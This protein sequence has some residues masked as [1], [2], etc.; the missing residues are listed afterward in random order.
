MILFL[1]KYPQAPQEYRDGFFQR[2]ENIDHFYLDEER[3]Y[4]S[5]SFLK[6][7][8]K[9]V[10]KNGLRTEIKCNVF[11]H[12]FIIFK[13]FKN[14][15]LIY[16]QSIYNAMNLFLF[17]ILFN[18]FYVLDLHGVVPEELEMQ[19]KK[20]YAFIFKTIEKFLFKKINICI[21]VTN[22]MANH[23]KSKYSESRTKY[24]VYAILPSHLKP[25]DI[26]SFENKDGKIEVIYSG[27]TQVWQNIDLMLKTIKN[28]QSESIHYT[29]LTGEP[30]AFNIRFKQYG[31]DKSQITVK[32]VKP[33]ELEIYYS[34]SHYGFVLRD[35]I[36]INSVACP[37]KI[38]EYLNY[39]I[40]PII[41]SEKIGDFESYGYEYIYL[42]QFSDQLK[43]KKSLKN[44]SV[45]HRIYQTNKF[46]LKNEIERVKL[47]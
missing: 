38:V 29:I 21:A 6:N 46:N 25:Y 18:K 5:A 12:F 34:A 16:I 7:F 22:R 35:D 44:I 13:L 41:L 14:S 45:I 40:I 15:S 31:I 26:S 9:D 1:S 27:N 17:I 8:K 4:L 47:S 20:N 23:Y 43:V 32:S 36:L 19:N 42:N 33:E 28:H 24:I 10:V 3:V 2:V 37:T 30:E 39:G 11:L